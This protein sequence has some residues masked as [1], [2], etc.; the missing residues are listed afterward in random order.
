M[1]PLTP[2]LVIANKENSRH[3]TFRRK[4]ATVITIIQQ[5]IQPDHH[6]TGEKRYGLTSI[7]IN[8]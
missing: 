6:L 2:S 1:Y 3:H 5:I 8:Q 4:K 7:L